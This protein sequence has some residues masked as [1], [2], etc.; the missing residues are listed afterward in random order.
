MSSRLPRSE[1]VAGIAR[2]VP[3]IGQPAGRA[4]AAVR[5]CDAARELL[6]ASAAALFIDEGVVSRAAASGFALLPP[7]G[8]PASL[9]PA[10]LETLARWGAHGGLAPVE[11]ALLCLEGQVLGALVLF[12]GDVEPLGGADL[13]LLGS[14]VACALEQA[15]TVDDLRRAYETQERTQEQVVRTERLRVLGEMALGIAH[16][17]NN[18]LNAML[19]QVGVLELLAD[20][21]RDLAEAIAR[22]KHVALDGAA[23]VSRLQDF[24]RQRR[25]QEFAELDLSELARTAMRALGERGGRELVLD[26]R[27]EPRVLVAGNAAEL[28]DV[29]D[30]VLENALEAK[31]GRVQVVLQREGDEARLA[32]AAAA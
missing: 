29:L 24:S 9:E 11:I 13:A 27:L 19:G 20:G 30:A 7:D 5:V 17:F 21:H 8:L 18:V 23:T 15:R 14:V 31:S 28:R 10:E 6:G 25:D 12:G 16:A 4:E 22:I 2:L 3:R 26:E 1:R 32:V